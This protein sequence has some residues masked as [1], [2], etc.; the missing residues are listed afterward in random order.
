MSLIFD[1]D[2]TLI[3]SR[4]AE[5][6]RKAR[7]WR[8]VY[9]LISKFTTYDGMADVLGKLRV[10]EIP[11]CIVTTSPSI[12][13][14]KVCTAWDIHPSYMVCYHD[15]PHSQLKPHPAS[16]LKA[17]HL[18]GVEPPDIL[19]FGDRDID[20]LASNSAGVSSV[21][22]L[23]GTDDKARLLAAKPVYT[24]ERPSQILELAA[25]V[26]FLDIK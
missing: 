8:L 3:D 13:C 9:P 14:Q 19:S 25:D 11:Y 2:Q 10:N 15:V 26:L 21:A 17:I 1:L 4:L 22:C 16:M 5:A 12:Y 23:W 6:K 20:I 24:I 7:Q 18:L